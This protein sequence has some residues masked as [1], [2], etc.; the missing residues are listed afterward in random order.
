[1]SFF[2]SDLRTTK[3]KKVIREQLSIDT[4]IN[5][6]WTTSVYSI[7]EQTGVAYYK[8]GR[9]YFVNPVCFDHK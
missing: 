6:G 3:T 9:R 2:N 4:M 8:P 1:M 7:G 5:V